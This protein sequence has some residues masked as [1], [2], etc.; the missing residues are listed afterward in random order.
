[1]SDPISSVSGLASGI[2]WRDLV[3][4][5]M[6][7]DQSRR[8]TPVT[9][10]KTAAQ[11]QSDAWNQYSTLVS[12]F[13]DAAAK[14]RDGSALGAY[15]ATAGTSATT[16]RSLLSVSASA[17]ASPGSYQVEVLDL[18]RAN[19][20]SGSIVASSTTALGLAGEF[21]V[22]GKRVTLVANDTLST[23]RDKINAVNAGTT[24][25]GV[26]A[27]ILSTGAGQQRLVL[28]SDAS[29]SA[30]IELTD[31]AA[32]T[33]GSLGIVDASKSLNVSAAGGS[34]TFHVSSATAAIATMMGVTMPPP[35][36][37]TI[38]GRVISVD[39]TVDSLTSIAAKINAAGA[40]ASV[41]SESVGGKTSYKLVADGTAAVDPGA[42]SATDSGRTLDVL[43]FVKNG[44]SA[45]TQVVQSQNSF[46]DASSGTGATT[47]TTLTDLAIGGSA[48]GLAAGDTFTIAGTRGDGSAVSTTLTVGASDT[49]QT[50]LTKIN[51]ATTGF[52]AGTRTATASFVNGQF[53]L[54]DAQ[55]GDSQLALSLSASTQNGVVSLGRMNVATVGRQREVVAGSDAQIRVDGVVVSRSSNT[56]SDVVAGVSLNLQ[57]A[58]PGSTVGVTIARDADGIT[59]S[60]DA[61]AKAYNDILTFVGDQQKSNDQPLYTRASLRTSFA[62]ITQRLLAPVTGVTGSYT[63]AGIA[64]LALQKDGTLALDQAKFKAALATNFTDVSRLFSSGGT[65]TNNSLSYVFST[66]ATKPGT[67]GVTITQAATI[68]TQSGSGFSGTYADD[69]TSDTMTIA[70]AVSGASGSIQLANGDTSQQI[71][72]K[73]NAL[74]GNN[75]MALT[76]SLNGADVVINGS[77]YGAGASFTVSYAGGGTDGS[78][79][80]G[81]AAGTYAGLD[82]AGSFQYTDA[83]G[84]TQTAAATG[85]GQMLTGAAG[86]PL[87]GLSIN[88]TD[89]ATGA[90]GSFSYTA[91]VGGALY[92]AADALVRLDGQVQDRRD[93]LAKRITYLGSRADT[94]QK[95][96]DARRQS[97]I[98]QY[99]AMESAI[100]RIQTQGSALASFI[101]GLNAASN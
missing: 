97:L 15:T 14:L 25:S 19:K 79:Q 37:I 7:V 29:G 43:G 95:A 64:G 1:M 74:F 36:T 31:D 88:Y 71:V 61:V 12:A 13:R 67:Y 82:V 30:G 23:V 96:L 4:Q 55:G 18:A 50:L 73:L 58:E 84:A 72:D 52:G 54:T 5:I 44:R 92:G 66:P 86:T 32:G 40:S 90:V 59:K 91:G 21:A 65:S 2:Q 100:S 46:D 24:P 9:D 60:V 101:N 80:L 27:S 49:V 35:S 63:R 47:A 8:L 10:S 81:L 38:N 34:Q 77:R 6:A 48:V 69:G 85:I 68:A 22:N 45:V 17:S 3:D 26:T 62:T 83:N 11:K 87:E 99:T 98:A 16:G 94:I 28:T 33:L 75:R 42:A 41:V 57:Q 70:D 93:E 51:D 89:V 76:A 20:V 39:L 56:I 53:V 78:A